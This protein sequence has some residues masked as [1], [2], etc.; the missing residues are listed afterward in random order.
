LSAVWQATVSGP[1]QPCRM[2]TQ[3]KRTSTGR[4]LFA[5]VYDRAS[6]ANEP[7]P[8]IRARSRLVGAARGRVLEIGAGTGAN[9]AHYRDVRQLTLSEPDPYMRDRLTRRAATHPGR[10]ALSDAP[11]EDL[12][13]PDASFDAVVS[14]LV[15]CSVTDPEA[16]AAQIHRVLRPGGRLYFL[17]H[18]R[19]HR[20][21]A[22]KWQDRLTPILRRLTGDHLNRDT[23]ATLRAAGL[24]IDETSSIDL[25]GPLGALQPLR[26]GIA[27]RRL[28]VPVDRATVP[29]IPARNQQD[30]S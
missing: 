12:P 19:S 7:G 22:A 14:T 20:P 1:G 9:L 23:V 5:A 4:R 27:H 21:A 17:E 16:A 6:G 13:W 8:V 11:A 10:L 30:R 2:T 25:P 28:A 26:H 24:I 29:D 3:T 18:V 15:L